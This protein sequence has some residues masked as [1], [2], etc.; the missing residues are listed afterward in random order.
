MMLK[1]IVVFSWALAGFGI[2]FLMLAVAAAYRQV[3]PPSEQTEQIRDA[4]STEEIASLLA[5]VDNLKTWLA[6][7][8]VG[9]ALLVVASSAPALERWVGTAPQQSD[10]SGKKQSTPSS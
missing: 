4:R 7:A 9:T 3:F 1:P 6:L 10:T 5:A 2:L 8:V